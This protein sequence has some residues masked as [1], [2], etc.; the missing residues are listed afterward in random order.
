M[1]NVKL[2]GLMSDSHDHLTNI[3]KLVT[4]FNEQKVDIAFHLGDYNSEFIIKELGNLNC[5][6]IG[7]LGEND[8]DV[9]SLL[10]A[11]S[12]NMEIFKNQHEIRLNDK[13]FLLIRDPKYLNIIVSSEQYNFIIFG[14]DH[15]LSIS[16][17]AN[18]HIINPGEVCG[19]ISGKAQAIIL[20]ILTGESQIIDLNT[21]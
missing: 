11:C 6:F 5:P 8:G 18:V 14:Q 12:D 19:Y 15:K 2:I 4:I 16:K 3:K 10:K 7:L 21:I 9:Y 13:N 1:D 17:N 20:N